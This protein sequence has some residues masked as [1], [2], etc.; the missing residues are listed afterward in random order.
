MLRRED[1]RGDFA[2]VQ[3]LK[4][5]LRHDSPLTATALAH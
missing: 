3:A 1:H 4:E 5:G 2:G